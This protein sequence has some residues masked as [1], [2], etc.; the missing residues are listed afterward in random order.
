MTKR[1][2]IALFCSRDF[3]LGS[4][5]EYGGGF[6]WQLSDDEICLEMFWVTMDVPDEIRLHL[7]GDTPSESPDDSPHRGAHRSDEQIFRHAIEVNAPEV[8]RIAEKN[9]LHRRT[10]IIFQ[11]E[12]I[13]DS[14][15]NFDFFQDE[16]INIEP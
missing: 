6:L 7:F 4:R 10:P 9:V 1:G 11:Y 5:A 2:K 16:E 14:N 3:V 8:L 12:S 15:D 13:A